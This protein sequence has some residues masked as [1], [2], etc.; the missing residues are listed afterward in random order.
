[1]PPRRFACAPA[2][3][4]VGLAISAR[5]ERSRAGAPSLR[6]NRSEEW[7]MTIIRGGW[8]AGVTSA[9]LAAASLSPARADYKI[10]FVTSLSGAATTIGIPYS[11][12]IA[13]AKEYMGEIS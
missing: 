2:R 5:A 11:R 7:I 8:V 1:M 9:V 3:N 4:V 12:G 13:A 10:G 6:R